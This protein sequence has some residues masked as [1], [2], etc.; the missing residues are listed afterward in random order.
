MI[1][2]SKK[3]EEAKEYKPTMLDVKAQEVI[4]EVHK[5]FEPYT[6]MYLDMYNKK[7]SKVEFLQDLK[8]TLENKTGQE[9]EELNNM[10][11]MFS[12]SNCGWDSYN[13]GYIIHYIILD[14]FY[15]SD[16]NFDSNCVDQYI[17]FN[18]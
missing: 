8:A 1:Y 10:H 14:L 17:M 13:V 5:L 12:T 16:K 7:I 9:L 15:P 18:N 6:K 4:V 11:K 3:L 2:Y